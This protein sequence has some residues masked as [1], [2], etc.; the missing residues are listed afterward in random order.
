MYLIPQSY[1]C[2]KCMYEYEWSPHHGC[3]TPFNEP[4]CPRCYKDFLDKHITIG[5]LKESKQ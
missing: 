1:I 2:Q 5:K 4:Y 3:I